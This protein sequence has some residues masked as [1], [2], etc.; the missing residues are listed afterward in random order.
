MSQRSLRSRTIPPAQV[1]LPSDSGD[2]PFGSPLSE[3]P[4]LEVP[5]LPPIPDYNTPINTSIIHREFTSGTSRM[6]SSDSATAG[7]KE[8]P[9]KVGE[10]LREDGTNYDNWL[11]ANKI[12]LRLKGCW[13][14]AAGKELRPT[15]GA[16]ASELRDWD[17]RANLAVAQFALNMPLSLIGQLDIDSAHKLFTDLNTRFAKSA[18]IREIL[19]SSAL[20]GKHIGPTETMADHINALRQLRVNYLNAGGLL[21][22]KE[23]RI[24]ILIS[25]GHGYWGRYAANF[26]GVSDPEEVIATLVFEERRIGADKVLELA[27]AEATVTAMVA[28]HTSSRISS[29]NNAGGHR[30]SSNASPQKGRIQ[31]HNCGARGHIKANCY[32]PGGGKQDNPPSWF[33][34]PPHMAHLVAQTPP[35]ASA[36]LQET[37][38][39]VQ[40][41]SLMASLEGLDSDTWILDSGAS[42]SMCHDRLSFHSLVMFDNPQTI[43]TAKAGDVLTA[44][45]KGSIRA[46]FKYDSLISVVTFN[47]VL[48]VPDLDSNLL[49]VSKLMD[50]NVSVSFTKDHCTFTK[51]GRP[52]GLALRLGSL[53]QVQMELARDSALIMSANKDV[54]QDLTLWHRRLAHINE[55]RVLEMFKNNTVNGLILKDQ[56][57]KGRCSSCIVGKHSATPSPTSIHRASYPLETLHSDIQFFDTV[58]LGGFKYALSFID[59]YT[60]YM[61]QIPLKDK[62]SQSILTEFQRVDNLVENQFK[63]RIRTLHSDNGGEYSNKLMDAYLK[64]RG[65]VHH[66]IAPHRHEMNGL[67][68]RAN[69]S[70]ADCVR[71]MLDDSKK[72]KNLWPL[73]LSYYADVRNFTTNSALDPSLSPHQVL[74]GRKPDV[75]HLRVFGCDAYMRVP[76]D[77]RKKLDAKS[78]KGTFVGLS[79]NSSY[80]ILLP[81]RTIVKSKDVIFIESP[82]S[83]SM[84]RLPEMPP[85]NTVDR[86]NPA[87][88]TS[89]QSPVSTDIIPPGSSEVNI[90]LALRKETRGDHTTDT[91]RQSKEQ[92]ST[93]AYMDNPVKALGVKQPR[94]VVQGHVIP[95]TMPEALSGPDKDEWQRAGAYELGMLLQHDVWDEVPRPLDSHVIR[96]KWV[97]N[98]KDEPSGLVFR[99]RWVARGDFQ[100]E[101]EYGELH[102]SS[103]DFNVARFLLALSALEQSTL[104]AIDI[105]SAYLHSDLVLDSPIFVEFPHGFHPRS[106]GFVCRLKRALYGLKQGARAWQDTFSAI[107]STFGFAP[108]TSS[109]STYR[110][111]D[112]QGETIMGTHVDDLLVKARSKS[113]ANDSEANRFELELASKFKFSKKDLSTGARILGWDLSHDSAAGIIR[114]SVKKKI[115]RIAQKYGLQDAKTASTPM[116]ENALSVFDKDD[117]DSQSDSSFPFAQLIG[118]LLWLAINARPDISF[119][120]QVLSRSLKDPK[121][122]HWVAAKR[123]VRYLMGTQELALQ[124]SSQAQNLPICYTDADWARDP[125]DRKSMS[126]YVFILAGA[127]VMWKVK[128]QTVVALSTAEAEYIAASY[129]T[130]EATWVRNFFHEIG[131]SFAAKPLQIFVDNQAAIK[132]TANPVYQSKTKHIDLAVHHIRDQFKSGN[133]SFTYT[134][135][136]DNIADIFTKPLPPVLHSKCVRALGLC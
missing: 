114:L 92:E 104:R 83:R 62:S 112:A 8:G 26:A 116:A 27:Q 106:P 110:R 43:T 122:C 84:S 16:S 52:F 78:I 98:I 108:L 51:D 127:A 65:I 34:V 99:A 85:D 48:Y 70:A 103:G 133:V 69:R 30:T 63:R 59:E 28:S 93:Y 39:T 134:P 35:P 54:R 90:P 96:G 125:S 89:I 31:C 123:V 74:Y 11:K 113:D 67:A 94:R 6:S 79:L 32:A 81:N 22:D 75:S 76:P 21:T 102:A 128:R 87:D 1:S 135:G 18:D 68:E 107:L 29:S 131:R 15:D 61:W 100:L 25:L 120:V 88:S 111:S 13:D 9:I 45:G 60:G 115:I 19:A 47:D 41:F 3:L 95:L 82:D 118:E 71:A 42:S 44:K 57:S 64:S 132:M 105:N 97:F 109:P 56:T 36:T 10:L 136:S 119:A 46:T 4:D 2:T 130:R 121:Q 117:Q 49:S 5:P 37:A 91:Y 77:T 33:K 72:P 73:A 55:R 58:G 50:G 53:Y 24:I 38:K 126:G 101:D 17:R 20:R 12:Q 129:A 80:Q 86:F 7:S 23:W 14:I 124:Y 40:H 66:T